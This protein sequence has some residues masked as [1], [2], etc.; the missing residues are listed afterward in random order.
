MDYSSIHPAEPPKL[1]QG[2]WAGRHA[3]G[4]LFVEILANGSVRTCLDVSP[5]RN[6]LA[7]KYADYALYLEDGARIEI[8]SIHAQAV[9]IYSPPGR[10]AANLV[11]ATGD[12]EAVSCFA[13]T[14]TGGGAVRSIP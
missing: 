1:L 9:T 6:Q 8:E 7:G 10:P 12:P 13:G 4:D 14:A 3:G 5:Y 11:L 2:V